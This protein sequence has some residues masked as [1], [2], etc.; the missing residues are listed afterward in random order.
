LRLRLQYEHAQRF[1]QSF[2]NEYRDMQSNGG[3]PGDLTE[4]ERMREQAEE[5]IQ[6]MIQ[7]QAQQLLDDAG[8]QRGDLERLRD[9]LRDQLQIHDMASST[10]STST[11]A[12]GRQSGQGGN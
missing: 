3:T 8:L 2:E 4:L 11:P 5:R 10:S 9:Q 12:G 1:Q 6:S 7:E